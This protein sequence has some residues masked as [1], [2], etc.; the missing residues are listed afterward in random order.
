M[1]DFVNQGTL[2]CFFQ[3]NY[4]LAGSLS[5]LF[6]SLFNPIDLDAMHIDPQYQ[7]TFGVGVRA[8]CNLHGSSGGCHV[9][10]TYCDDEQY[11]HEGRGKLDYLFC[12]K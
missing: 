1:Y 12:Q 6:W 7:I 2:F 8:L 9:E 10:C 4:R 11:L 5:R 3:I